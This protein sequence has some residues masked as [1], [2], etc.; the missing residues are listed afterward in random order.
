MS[1]LYLQKNASFSKHPVFSEM[2]SRVDSDHQS[3]SDSDDGMATL[4]TNE[5]GKTEKP[6]S[7]SST[8][9]TKP[10][11]TPKA[12]T[13]AGSVR[14]KDFYAIKSGAFGKAVEICM[15]LVIQLEDGKLIAPYLLTSIDHWDYEKERLVFVM[16]NVLLCIKYNFSQTKPVSV[17]RAPYYTM[18]K[19]ETGPF[20]YPRK[21]FSKKREGAGVRI[22]WGTG[23]IDLLSRWNPWS[24]DVP[25]WT[26]T[27]HP[28][29][30]EH[31]VPDERLD[32]K[33]FSAQLESTIREAQIKF[34]REAVTFHEKDIFIETYA[35]F[36]ANVHNS[37]KWG[38]F[39]RK[40]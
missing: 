9:S 22:H 29:S 34:G 12:V 17:V 40:K 16:E 14:K 38:F 31:S 37:R 25:F 24:K 8:E 30:K 28:L 23:A 35:G 6:T 1:G 21:S 5:G 15:N 11:S 32:V 2:E 33:T 10:Q 3:E 26:F 36:P 27:S 13:T 20:A 39:K 18:N 7:V 4:D 19:V